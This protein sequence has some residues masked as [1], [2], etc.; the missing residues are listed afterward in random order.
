MSSSFPPRQPG[1]ELLDHLP[2]DDPGAQA[3]RRDLRRINWLMGQYRFIATALDRHAREDE[4][5]LEIGA[6]DGSLY[7]HLSQHHRNSDWNYT[8]LD[9]APAPHGFE[10]AW[11]QKSVF[12]FEA[13]DHYPVVIANLFLHHFTNEELKQLGTQIASHSRLLIINEPWRHPFPILGFNFLLPFVHP[14]TR[15]DGAISL[16]AGFCPGEMG[17]LLGL[18]KP[19]WHLNEHTSWRGGCRMVGYRS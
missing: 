5:I 11:I 8:G 9:I 13:W 2:A 12:D 3:S 6:G 18:S 10:K 17:T 4:P 1:R 16:R 14:I 15:H 7:T 19:S